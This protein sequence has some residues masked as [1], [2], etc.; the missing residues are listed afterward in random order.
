M[1]AKQPTPEPR[2]HHY[3]PRLLL[4]GFAVERKR[5]K[6]QTQVF[7]KQTGRT[8]A[9][10]I[11]DVMV[12]GDFNSL[13]TPAGRL[14][15]EAYVGDIES[16]AAPI[17]ERIVGTA[18]LGG[19]SSDDQLILATFGALQFVRG[20]AQREMSVAL[21]EA[22][23]KRISALD[24]NAAIEIRSDEGK[25]FGLV[26]ITKDLAE[27]A[28]HFATKDLVLFQA[29]SGSDF[30]LGD[31][32]VVLE[33]LEPS[34]FFGNLGL[35]CEGIQIGLPISRRLQLNFWC[36]SILA[37][38]KRSR[39][40][41]ETKVR[42]INAVALLSPGG[43]SAEG[44]KML[45][46]AQRALS[47][48]DPLIESHG[49]GGALQLEPEHVVRANSLQVSHAERYIVSAR[50]DFS[51]AAEMIAANPGFKSGRRMQVS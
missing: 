33:N 16:K 34:D 29:P 3:V 17:I 13:E 27:Y 51:L 8:F 24:A 20:T 31:N 23:N 38:A 14:S 48:V 32:P 50:G 5:G 39:D 9:A 10:S 40:E 49:G 1:S 6:F 18:S 15:L 42:A 43:L 28:S 30:I 26:S 35:S 19:L 46:A 36:P 21:A 25:R 11:N 7:D 47:K 41:V 12:E 45:D 4:K 22:V 44:R 2:R 37:K